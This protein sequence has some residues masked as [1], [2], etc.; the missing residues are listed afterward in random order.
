MPSDGK[1][2]SLQ[3]VASFYRGGV[4]IVLFLFDPYFSLKSCTISCTTISVGSR[5]ALGALIVSL[6]VPEAPQISPQTV[7]VMHDH[8]IGK[9]VSLQL[10]RSPT[11]QPILARVRLSVVTR[12]LLGWPSCGSQSRRV[13]TVRDAQ[14]W[15]TGGLVP[16]WWASRFSPDS[17]KGR[18]CDTT[19]RVI[20]GTRDGQRALQELS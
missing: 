18:R 6:G 1:S 10:G 19:C 9:I 15:S 16:Q 20:C 14:C 8:Q 17:R 5:E 2:Q 13:S 11:Q 3:T 12:I 4:N 7:M